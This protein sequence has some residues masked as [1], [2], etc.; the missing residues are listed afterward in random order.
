VSSARRGSSPLDD[1]DRTARARIRDAAFAR[2]A[3]DG[4]AATSVKSLAADAGVSPALVIH[5]FGSKEGLRAA[6]DEYVV[7]GH[8]RLIRSTSSSSSDPMQVLRQ[9]DESLP[10]V[11]YLA[12]TLPDPS[13]HVAELVDELLDN[14]LASH[15]EW[16]E[17]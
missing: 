15:P 1:P 7:E 5:H 8:R 17:P 11:A 3:T 2:F 12:R 13:P 10:I 14:A 16:V 9:I 6:C 4:V